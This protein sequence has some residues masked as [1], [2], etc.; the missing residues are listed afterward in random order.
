MNLPASLLGIIVATL[1]LFPSSTR[2][3]PAS[4]LGLLVVVIWLRRARFPHRDHVIV[5]LFGL[6]MISAPGTRHAM[7]DQV[8]RVVAGLLLFL[9]MNRHSL[10]MLIPAILIAGAV[11]SAD[12]FLAMSV[13]VAAWRN[14]IR[15]RAEWLGVVAAV[16]LL[17]HMVVWGLLKDEPFARL[18]APAASRW[19]AARLLNGGD[20]RVLLRATWVVLNARSA[21]TE[22]RVRD[23]L[24]KI[25]KQ[26]GRTDATWALRI[27]SEAAVG[28]VGEARALLAEAAFRSRGV[29]D[30]LSIWDVELPRWLP[31]ALFVHDP[32]AYRDQVPGVEVDSSSL[33][34]TAAEYLLRALA[35]A[36]LEA[37]ACT[38]A[39]GKRW[40]TAGWSRYLDWQ[41]H[42]AT[43][44]TNSAQ[45]VGRGSIVLPPGGRYALMRGQPARGVWPEIAYR[46]PL[47]RGQSPLES[48]FWSLVDLGTSESCTLS[49]VNDLRSHFEDRNFI[50]GGRVDWEDSR[51]EAASVKPV[52]ILQRIWRRI[53]AWQEDAP[54]GLNF[55]RADSARAVVPSEW[56]EAYRETTGWLLPSQS[57]ILWRNVPGGAYDMVLRGEPAVGLW[58]VAEIVIDG[59]RE[60][61][62]VDGWDWAE[63]SVEI[64]AESADVLLRLVNDYWDPSTAEDRNLWCWGLIPKS[65]D[66]EGRN[67]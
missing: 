46:T 29:L 43:V 12:L 40:R 7:T 55:A 56:H 3:G 27:L 59:T 1:W 2:M 25:E 58:P 14:R 32:S 19:K 62:L 5:V 10:V 57:W 48:E 28:H 35:N 34:P 20:Q 37:Q 8:L 50:V 31:W 45:I 47:Q 60:R 39:A 51:L 38:L 41:S 18:D 53:A 4:A 61:R 9:P 42:A 17:V 36:G 6:L 67:E 44:P 21:E 66:S 22:Q 30:S 23:L 63:S 16:T 13:G 15:L 65:G 54:M 52:S 33:D 26:T 24:A 64:Q 49:L 11:R